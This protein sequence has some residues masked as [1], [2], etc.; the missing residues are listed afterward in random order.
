MPKEGHAWHFSWVFPRREAELSSH[1]ELWA[2]LSENRPFCTGW[3]SYWVS[4]VA[5]PCP[6]L[7]H[8]P[9]SSPTVVIAANGQSQMYG[10]TRWARSSQATFWMLFVE[11]W[12]VQVPSQKGLDWYIE[13]ET[14]KLMKVS[15]QEK[16]MLA[17][18]VTVRKFMSTHLWDNP[19]NMNS[20]YLL[21]KRYIITLGW[22]WYTVCNETCWAKALTSWSRIWIICFGSCV[23]YDSPTP[24][25]PPPVNDF[26]FLLLLV[27]ICSMI[28]QTSM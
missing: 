23:F 27:W 22:L 5:E 2:R 10:H 9:S 15:V 26:P 19:V 6:P 25:P 21:V 20:W 14:N 18:C 17:V 11:Y 4:H 13:P 7:P 8:A 28:V 16:K 12:N 3:A 1:C 24:R